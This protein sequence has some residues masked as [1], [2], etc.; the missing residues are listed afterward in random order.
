MRNYNDEK[1]ILSSKKK[2]HT[3]I[4]NKR[5]MQKPKYGWAIYYCKK[6]YDSIKF[7]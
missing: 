4:W 1:K 7:H 2:E 5:N 6:C 3:N